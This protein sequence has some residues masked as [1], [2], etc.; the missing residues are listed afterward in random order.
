[1]NSPSANY[2]AV[3]P[4]AGIGARMGAAIPKQY[5][6]LHGGTVIERTVQRFLSHPRISGVVVVIAPDDV[7]WPR[8]PLHG[9]ASSLFAVEGGA[10]RYHS[11][12]NGLMWLA[13]MARPHDWVLV[14]DAARPCIRHED[15]DRLIAT[16]AD[17][18]VGGLLGVPVAD[19]VKR[20]DSEGNILET[21]PRAGLWRALTPQMFRLGD[22]TSALKHVVENNLAVTDEAA[23]MELAG[24]AP[25]MVEGH[26]DN[27][28]IT[29]PQDLALAEL[30]LKQQEA[31]S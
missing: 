11:V 28:K 2:W 14:H 10:E 15:I 1:M 9:G 19:T 6:P 24:H 23:A 13:G 21:V 8:T 29:V 18:P 5:L 25:R 27:I 3:I 16:L 17:H 7:H 4:A 12:L 31:F 26:A 30:Y 20:A 22:L